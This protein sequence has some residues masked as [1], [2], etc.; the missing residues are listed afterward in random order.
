MWCLT[1]RIKKNDTYNGKRTFEVILDML[2]NHKISGATVWTGTAGFGKRGKSN[3]KIEGISIN[4]PLIIEVIE[5]KQKLQPMLP[6]IKQT[7]GDNG[8]VTLQ[9]VDML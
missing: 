4:M 6:E 1:I 8:M 2:K 5:E 3:F 9:E 7:V